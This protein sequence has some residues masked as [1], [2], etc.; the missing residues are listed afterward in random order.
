LA[1]IWFSIFWFVAPKGAANVPKDRF[2]ELSAETE[3]GSVQNT[4]EQQARPYMLA[5]VTAYFTLNTL[6]YGIWK[7]WLISLGAMALVVAILS[8]KAVRQDRKLPLQL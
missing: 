8:I 2:V 4:A 6:S 7:A 3:S 5:A 1:A